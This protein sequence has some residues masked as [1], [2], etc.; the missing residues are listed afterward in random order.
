ML[1]D[2]LWD[3]KGNNARLFSRKVLQRLAFG[4]FIRF[5]RDK[6]VVTLHQYGVIMKSDVYDLLD[7]FK[8]PVRQSGF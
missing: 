8:Q 2:G 1:A 4:D 7:P 5:D 6:L 3:E